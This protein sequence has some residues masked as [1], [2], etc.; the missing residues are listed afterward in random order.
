MN[1]PQYRRS[2]K[3]NQET[4]PRIEMPSMIKILTTKPNA[5]SISV[6]FSIFAYNS[7]LV[8]QTNINIGDQVAWAPSSQILASQ[9]KYIT[10][11]KFRVFV[12]KAAISG[13]HLII[14]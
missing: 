7:I 11:D 6:S 10:L 12:L 3:E 9:F 5:F 14:L 8:Q 1:L 2:Q 4:H 13:P